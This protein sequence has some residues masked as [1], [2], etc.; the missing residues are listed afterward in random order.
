MCCC[1]LSRDRPTCYFV[2]WKMTSTTNF[3][4]YSL[5]E[6]KS[7]NAMDA[8][9]TAFYLAV[10]RTNMCI[11]SKLNYFTSVHDEESLAKVS[12]NDISIKLYFTESNTSHFLVLISMKYI[13]CV[14]WKPF[15]TFVV[16][17]N[18]LLDDVQFLTIGYFK[19]KKNRCIPPI[20]ISFSISLWSGM[21]NAPDTVYCRWDLICIY[22]IECKISYDRLRVL[23]DLIKGSH[24]NSEYALLQKQ[25]FVNKNKMVA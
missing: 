16:N 8:R 3:T 9:F 22:N 7:R 12:H 14:H 5:V 6:L 21:F 24:S 25:D 4:G 20:K 11:H 2:L 19:R 18:W 10:K 1:Q 15:L 17:S 23:M 13:A